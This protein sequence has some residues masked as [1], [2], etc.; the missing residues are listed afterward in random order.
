MAKQTL[1]PP[2]TGSHMPP[3]TGDGTELGDTWASLIAK[4][5]AMFGDLY[6]GVAGATVGITAGTTR[7]QA[8][9]T[10]LSTGINRVDTSTAPSTGS[11]LG[12]GVILPASSPDRIFVIN[13]TANII[14]VYGNGS[15]T[16][17]GVAG[18]TGIPLPSGD[19]G[20]FVCAAAGSWNFDPGIGAS[21]ALP[22]VLAVTGVAA[23]GNSQSTATQLVADFN[24]VT[25]ATASSAYG[26]ALP[27]AKPGL[28]VLIENHTGISIQV[29]GNNGAGDTIDDV[30]TATG[31]VQMDSSV[32]IYTCYEAGKWY[33]NGLATGYAKNPQN[34]VVLETV[35][36]ADNLTALTGGQGSALQL[37]AGINTIS[38]CPS[39]GGVNLP[40][41][42]P[43]LSVIVQNNGANGL[44]VY[45][46]Q[47]ASDT[48]N[49]AAASVG[50]LLFPGTA[51]SFN[52][53]AA[54]AWTTQPA[55]TRNSIYNSSSSA[56]SFTATAA[57]I[58][59]GAAFVELD[60][61][62]NPAGA[63]NVTLPTVAAMVAAMHAPAVGSSFTLR[64]KN[65]ANSGTW[66]MVTNTGWALS[67]TVTVA[68]GTWR[69]FV[70]TLTSL[71]AAT[72][73]NAGGGATL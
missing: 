2:P 71:T 69:D 31:V 32:V 16:I 44:L 46:A 48:I 59:G 53:T 64:V 35:Q 20:E 25:T 72:L 18:A 34:G 17:N 70:V 63:A 73:Q 29:Y 21:G 40:A 8:G 68:T 58:T 12:D 55:T 5:N 9:A 15:D 38:T 54:G 6:S 14:Q 50:V 67:G 39:G 66:T 26:V 10:A 28:D 13:N 56:A 30:A 62:G 23:A 42:A 3:N 45:P 43:G 37:S 24:K 1:N 27:V 52:C 65:S 60:L 36:F 47:G 22:L 41:S 19:V 33:S 61:T 4:L 49:G 11:T 7:T 51:A 57:N